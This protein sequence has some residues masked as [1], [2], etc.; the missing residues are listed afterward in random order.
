MKYKNITN[1]LIAAALLLATLACRAITGSFFPVTEGPQT[2]LPATIVPSLQPSLVPTIPPAA[3][4]NITDQIMQIANAVSE[5]SDTVENSSRDENNET[6]LVTYTISGNE[7]SDPV[8]EDVSSD[9]QN[10]QDDTATQQDIWNYFTTL[11]PADERQILVEY[12]IMTDG[13]DN[14]LAAVS[15]TYDDPAL[16]NLEVDIADTNDT[17]N[18]T[19]TLVH[20]FGHLLTLNPDQVPPSI[21]I[22]NNPDDENIYLEEVSACPSYFPGE[23]CAKPNSYL[24]TFYNQ[25]WPDIHDELQDINLEEK[26]DVYYQRLDDFY[27]KYQDQFVNEYSA[28]NP[29]ED[30]AEAWSFFVLGPKPN[31]DT[32]AEEKILFFY[33]YPELVQLREQILSNLCASLPQ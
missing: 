30:I 7:I 3:C 6:I 13:Q 21:A 14:L 23:G 29:E 28:T 24:N 32:I 22:F 19:Y 9:L 17:Y 33:N 31:G 20:E 8:Y 16:W 10:Q 18:L 15:Q 26:D 4:P 11:I 1:G 12:S 5:E 25:F 2:L 27:T